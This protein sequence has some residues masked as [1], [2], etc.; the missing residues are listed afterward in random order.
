MAK[1]EVLVAAGRMHTGEVDYL[2][3]ISDVH[4]LGLDTW[5]FNPRMVRVAEKVGFVYEGR[6]REM[7]Q[8]QGE[9]LD[10]MHF[11]ILREEW[12]GSV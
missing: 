9:W 2:F 11:G 5:S 6:Q 3:G 7:R 8:W 4:K 12:E 10:L 1:R